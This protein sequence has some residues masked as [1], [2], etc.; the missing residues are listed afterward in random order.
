L[1][2][3]QV[4]EPIDETVYVSGRR[5][6]DDSGGLAHTSRFDGLGVFLAH[7][8]PSRPKYIRLRSTRPSFPAAS[9]KYSVLSP[10]PFVDFCELR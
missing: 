6:L 3:H 9:L 5:S 10:T 8:F 2:R 7:F 1:P 4:P